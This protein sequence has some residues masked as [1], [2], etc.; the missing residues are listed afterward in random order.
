MES[1]II[2]EVVRQWREARPDL[3]PSALAVVGRILR[4]GGH[5]ERRAN[6]VLQEFELPI[7]GFDVL[8]T[9]RRRGKPYAMT[10]TELMRSTMLTSG[11]ITNRI[12]RLERQGLVERLPDPNDR[13]SLQVRLTRKGLKLVDA[14]TGI[15]FEEANQAI[16]SLSATEVAKL[17][18]LLRKMLRG[19]EP[20]A[21]S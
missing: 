15:R 5:L 6:L 1:D 14:T 12:D 3:D 8:G 16:A 9:L 17:E 10:P 11:A 13:R 2:D 21:A 7:G 19:L 4:L 20:D 18:T